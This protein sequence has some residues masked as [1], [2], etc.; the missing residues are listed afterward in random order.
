M[1]LC[2]GR[3]LGMFGRHV[4][5]MGIA[6]VEKKPR[7]PGMGMVMKVRID[8][9]LCAGHG[10]CEAAAPEVFRVNDDWLA[11]VLID[12]PPE[13]MRAAVENA[14]RLCPVKAVLV[15]EE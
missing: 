12:N 1:D 2:V 10:Q 13:S 3:S 15:E 8:P 7:R 9:A 5:R 6:V 14:A 4:E 11:E